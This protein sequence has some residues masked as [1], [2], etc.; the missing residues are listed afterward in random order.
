MHPV[1]G[2]L[3]SILLIATLASAGDDKREHSTQTQRM[4]EC[5]AKAHEGNLSGDARKQ[6]MSE[7][8]KGHPAPR[9]ADAANP[10]GSPAHKSGDGEHHGQG[11]KMKTCNQEAIAK[12]LRGDDRKSFMSQCLKADRS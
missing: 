7:C 2:A 9:E 10:K 4:T 3:A 11:E 12:N 1:L 6:F 8:L 5:N